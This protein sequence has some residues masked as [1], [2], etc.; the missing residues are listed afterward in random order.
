MRGFV[1]ENTE[2]DEETH[3]ETLRSKIRREMIAKL[4]SEWNETNRRIEIYSWRLEDEMCAAID[5]DYRAERAVEAVD[6][7]ECE[8]KKNNPAI[9]KSEL[10]EIRKK[11]LADYEAE[12]ATH[13][14]IDYDRLE[15]IEELLSELGA[16]MMRPYEHWNEEE[17]YMEYMET[18]YDY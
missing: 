3:E 4:A 9:T 5:A 6:Y 11:A 15:V 16:R 1:Y 8:A 18:R 7:A 14:R 12:E 13:E 2:Y 17:K 10:Q